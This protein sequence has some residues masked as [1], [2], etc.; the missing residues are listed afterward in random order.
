MK[1]YLLL[2]IV[3]L[4]TSVASAQI[5]LGVRGGV[6]LASAKISTSALDAGN[7][8]G[9]Q[10]GLN[11]E[12]TIPLIGLGLETG[13]MYGHKKYKNKEKEENSKLSNYDY[14]SIPL[15]IKQRFSLGLVG[16]YLSAGA[17]GNVKLGG[18]NLKIF[19]DTY[20]SY[21]SKDFILGMNFGA[22]VTLLKKVDVGLYYRHQLSDSY[23]EDG[24]N[25]GSLI[26]SEGKERS[27]TM[28]AVYFF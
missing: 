7:R 12:G 17:Y 24:V 4:S 28:S 18:K 3:I 10:I 11:A 5:R 8:L 25:I 2:A 13:L 20:H 19:E 9:F 15:N 27:W 21:K 23:K 6:D 14:L 26:K 22:G 1:K 16:A